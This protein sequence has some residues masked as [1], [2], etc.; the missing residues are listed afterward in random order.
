MSIRRRLKLMLLA[1]AAI[2]AMLTA[3]DATAETDEY[4]TTCQWNNCL[5][6]ASITCIDTEYVWCPKYPW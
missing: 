4:P 2:A 5:N 3:S 1:G 6:F